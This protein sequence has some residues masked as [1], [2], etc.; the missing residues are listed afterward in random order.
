MERK[1]IFGAVSPRAVLGVLRHHGDVSYSRSRAINLG[2][3]IANIIGSPSTQK[4]RA[5]SGIPIYFQRIIQRGGPV[6]G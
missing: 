5:I 2:G 6:V 3:C 4:E 1:R